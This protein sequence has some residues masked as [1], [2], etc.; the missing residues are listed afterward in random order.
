MGPRLL[1]PRIQR[2]RIRNRPDYTSGLRLQDWIG[3]SDLPEGQE[4]ANEASRNASQVQRNI[5]R[6]NLN[7]L[8]SNLLLGR[9]SMNPDSSSR[10]PILSKSYLQ[11]RHLLS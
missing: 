7:R 8:S 5:T 10:S 6:F 3:G 11:P 2:S 4:R 1:D 9:Q